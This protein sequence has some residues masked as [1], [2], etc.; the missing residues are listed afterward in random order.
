MV[1]LCATISE[2]TP[3]QELVYNIEPK[4]EKDVSKPKPSKQL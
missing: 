1:T 2:T 4:G 3:T